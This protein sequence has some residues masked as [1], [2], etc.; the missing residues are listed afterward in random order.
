MC[1]VKRRV[2]DCVPIGITC[3]NQCALVL[4]SLITSD[5]RKEGRTLTDVSFPAHLQDKRLF[6]TPLGQKSTCRLSNPG[7]RLCCCF[8]QPNLLGV[9]SDKEK[10]NAKMKY[11]HRSGWR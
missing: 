8:L 4:T 1:H 5:R 3:T 7:L 10:I 9:I 6:K 2:C 11:K